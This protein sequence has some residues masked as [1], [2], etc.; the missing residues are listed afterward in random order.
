GP[1]VRHY[2]NGHDLLDLLH[3]DRRA[4]AHA[5]G[6]RTSDAV[7]AALFG[8]LEYDSTCNQPLFRALFLRVCQ[9]S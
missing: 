1:D 8:C 7:R 5:K 9:T 4:E 3:W 2:M 6:L